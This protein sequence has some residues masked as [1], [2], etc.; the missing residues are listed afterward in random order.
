MSRKNEQIIHWP[1]G[2]SRI[3]DRITGHF[4]RATFGRY[5]DLFAGSMAIPLACGF[6][7][8]IINDINIVLIEIYKEIQRDPSEL[9][10]YLEEFNKSEYNNKDEFNKLRDKF[11]V[12]KF[13][14]YTSETGALLIYLN[15]RCFN[16]LYREN[17]KGHFN[18]SYKEFKS[19]I[20]KLETFMKLH[21]FL[22]SKNIQFFHTDYNFYWNI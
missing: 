13:A 5:V 19:D 12:L 4:K 18:A 22:K 20:Y 14:P 17:Q 15:K 9:L 16:G 6:D 11:N 1:G 7:N 8:M 10:K 21:L 2:K 3:V